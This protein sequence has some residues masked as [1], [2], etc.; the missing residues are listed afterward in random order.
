[1]VLWSLSSSYSAWELLNFADSA[2]LEATDTCQMRHPNCLENL[3]L[4]RY[5]AWITKSLLWFLH[6]FAD[7]F[8]SSQHQ[9]PLE[10]FTALVARCEARFWDMSFRRFYPRV[11]ASKKGFRG[12]CL[13]VIRG[14]LCCRHSSGKVDKEGEDRKRR[15]RSLSH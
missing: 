10:S 9:F 11:G 15:T 3:C 12:E 14:F 8:F 2:H 7:C 5:I 13:R 4:S 6:Y 1:M